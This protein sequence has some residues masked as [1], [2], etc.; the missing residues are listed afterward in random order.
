MCAGSPADPVAAL[1]P[2][3]AKHLPARWMLWDVAD[4]SQPLGTSS[5]LYYERDP[6]IF[7]KRG[8]SDDPSGLEALLPAE[9]LLVLAVPGGK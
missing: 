1:L 2:P 8:G 4:L 5:L 7:G 3:V 9:C 6:A